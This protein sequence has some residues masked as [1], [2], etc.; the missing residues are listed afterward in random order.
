M[1]EFLF[2]IFNELNKNFYRQGTEIDEVEP[3]DFF[4]YWNVEGR[5]E[6]ADNGVKRLGNTYQIYFY[7]HETCLLQDQ[8][9]LENEM[10]KFIEKARS[11]GLSCTE[12][13]DIDAPDKYLGTTCRVSYAQHK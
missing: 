6:Y 5:G 4:T 7:C 13:N 1:K 8:N 10:N 11:Y 3:T 2:L 9:Y 12:P